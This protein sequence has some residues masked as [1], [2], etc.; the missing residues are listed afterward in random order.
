MKHFCNDLLTERYVA[1][2]HCIL[3]LEKMKIQKGLD[4]YST[5]K[6]KP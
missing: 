4:I 2:L 5:D 3:G 1:D 6:G